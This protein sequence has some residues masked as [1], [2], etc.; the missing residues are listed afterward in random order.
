M[1]QGQR[2]RLNK[3][4]TGEGM[5]VPPAAIPPAV[6]SSDDWELKKPCV[7]V[8]PASTQTVPPPPLTLPPWLSGCYSFLLHLPCPPL[9]NNRTDREQE[10]K[11]VGSGPVVKRQVTHVCYKPRLTKTRGLWFRQCWARLL[12]FGY[13]ALCWPCMT[14]P[15][16]VI[17]LQLEPWCQQAEGVQG[18][19][20]SGL[21]MLKKIC[22]IIEPY[23]IAVSAVK[24]NF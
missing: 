14:D 10:R 18:Q 2:S 22:V 19:I 16:H 24:I 7:W 9:Y 15:Y 1:T 17:S 11:T 5:V 21:D 3:E 8:P 13:L 12:G 23:D 6:S 20:V 4:S